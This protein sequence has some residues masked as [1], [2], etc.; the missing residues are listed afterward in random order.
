MDERDHAT[1]KTAI[2]IY[3]RSSKT[4]WRLAVS[5]DHRQTQ[6]EIF[7]ST[8]NFHL[9]IHL[10]TFCMSTI[11]AAPKAANASYRFMALMGRNKL[12]MQRNKRAKQDKSKIKR[13]QTLITLKTNLK[14]KTSE[15][16]E[17]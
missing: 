10:I 7:F 5:I 17:W 12:D 14:A 6:A 8:N 2:T 3:S 1:N 9:P 16:P 11:P 15:N 13:S 4:P